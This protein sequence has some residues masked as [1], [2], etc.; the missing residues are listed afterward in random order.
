MLFNK[1]DVCVDFYYIMILVN[2][3]TKYSKVNDL[4]YNIKYL[5]LYL[6]LNFPLAFLIMGNDFVF[7]YLFTQW[8]VLCLIR[9]VPNFFDLHL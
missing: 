7:I 3:V 9:Y 1:F 4:C 2:K 8:F 5:D 6:S